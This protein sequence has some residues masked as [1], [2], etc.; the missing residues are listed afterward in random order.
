LLAH[1]RSVYILE[2]GE[3]A[4]VTSS[5]VEVYNRERELISK[6]VFKVNWDAVKAEKSGYPHFMIKEIMEQPSAVRETLRSRLDESGRVDLS[7]E[8][9][10]S[11]EEMQSLEKIHL[12]ACGTAYHA[13]IV[14]KYTTETLLRLKCEVDV[15][16]EFRYRDPLL[17]KKDLV[18]VISQ[19]GETADTL[20]ALRL[21]REKGA[22]V[23]SITNVVGSTISREADDVLFTWAGP[24]IAVASTKAY[25]TQLTTL[26]LFAIYLGQ[27][28][29]TVADKEADTL[30]RELAILPDLVSEIMQ[31]ERLKELRRYS[32]M[33]AGWE[34]AFFIGRNLDFAVAM[35]GA[36]KLKEISYIHAESY[37]AGELKHGTLALI[38]SGIP[39]LALA[40]QQQVLEKTVSNIQEVK[41]RDGHVFTVAFSGEEGLEKEVDQ[42]FY[43]PRTSDILSPVLA[44]VPLQLISYYTA[45]ERGCPVDKPR[46]LAKSVTVE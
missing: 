10:L 25:L 31:E 39:V 8:L 38:T 9:K 5:G 45:V 17:D 15:A 37:A 44:V 36:L 27:N 18:I 29:G 46:N 1:T 16:S 34:N 28:R 35:E 30:G 23:L 12:V 14:G 13:G 32:Q 2:D 24:E 26:Y 40:T 43:L 11:R 3:T 33:L 6:E 21:A 42:V 41:A 22:R 7:G 4:S 19:S 20:A